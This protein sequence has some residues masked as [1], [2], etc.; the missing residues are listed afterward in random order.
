MSGRLLAQDAPDTG[1]AGP[2]VTR[3]QTSKQPPASEPA[4]EPAPVER[5][6]AVPAPEVLAPAPVYDKSIFQGPLPAGEL[7]FLKTFDGVRTKDLY[8][9]KQFK[10]VKKA[11]LPKWEFHFGHDMSV[12]AAMDAA[13]TDSNEAVQVRDGRYVMLSGR[14][15]L[16]PGLQGKGF[17][18]IDMQDGLLLGGFYFHPTNGEPTPSMTVFSNQ[19]LVDA[20]SMAELPPEFFTDFIQWTS[21]ERIS[22]VTTRY[23]IGG[24]DKR[25]LLEHDE[26]FCSAAVGP[27]GSDC[28][29]MTADAADVDMNTA[30]YLEQ[31]H[32]ATNATAWMIVGSDETA[33]IRFRDNRCRG[34]VDPLGCR[35]RVTREQ[36][37]TITRPVSAPRPRR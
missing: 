8:R 24:L 37:H 26:D 22:P 31:V 34:V 23:F 20:L 6:P 11:A 3:P 15:D 32:Y 13:L 30:Y 18:W 14:S 25:I 27:M 36:V 29:Q 10:A 16:F 12:T 35:I 19:L 1:S 5:M 17:L 4:A 7:S 33:F 9:D 21:D 2:L 28:L